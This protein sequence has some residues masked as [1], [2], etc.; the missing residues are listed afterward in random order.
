MRGSRRGEFSYRDF[1][2]KGISCLP[3]SLKYAGRYLLA[4]AS[5]FLR[6]ATLSSGAM[7]F[8]PQTRFVL[9]V[10]VWVAIVLSV[11]AQTARVQFIHASPYA[12]VQAFDVYRNGELWLDD[13][14]Y[15][16]A[17]PFTDWPRGTHFRL[18]F[19]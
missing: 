15:E 5:R 9:T 17:T 16:G 3:S 7:L 19:T 11:Q 1:P 4:G 12:E 2:T 10:V 8:R 14:A 6:T 13:F 18:D